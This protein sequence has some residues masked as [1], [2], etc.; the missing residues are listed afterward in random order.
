MTD[1]ERNKLFE[2]NIG[3]VY[4]VLKRFFRNYKREDSKDNLVQVGMIGLWNA[5]KSFEKSRGI[6]FSTYAV[7]GIRWYVL[8]AIKKRTKLNK[9]VPFSRL[10]KETPLE[11][12]SNDNEYIVDYIQ[13]DTYDQ[14]S[15]WESIRCEHYL[16]YLSPKER[17]LFHKISVGETLKKIAQE[18][19]VSYQAIS[20]RI[21]R[22]QKRILAIREKEE[23]TIGEQNAV[24]KNDDSRL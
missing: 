20:L 13:Q 3:L 23:K 18:E 10:I 19:N 11:E 22:I 2:E 14:D 1:E 8:N 9:E 12:N 6:K 24:G 4:F 5:T 16:Q 7:K 17:E 15:D 21:I